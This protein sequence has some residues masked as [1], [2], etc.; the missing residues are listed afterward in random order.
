MEDMW[1]RKI[2]PVVI[3]QI[4]Y[5]VSTA[6]Y[7]VVYRCHW[8]VLLH[9]DS[10]FAEGLE[11]GFHV[12][13]CGRWAGC[14]AYWCGGRLGDGFCSVGSQ[15]KSGCW[16]LPFT[17]IGLSANLCKWGETV[18]LVSSRGLAGERFGVLLCRESGSSFLFVW[19]CLS[20]GA[21]GRPLRCN[22]YWGVSCFA[23]T[24]WH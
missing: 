16:Q 7:A 1:R 8:V 5:I 10:V 13:I 4:I 17:Y 9:H 20:M 23:Q 6:D 12:A 2:V 14:L 19:G 21:A 22:V 3:K 15:F 18:R 24:V 11:S